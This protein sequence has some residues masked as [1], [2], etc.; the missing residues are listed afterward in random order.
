[1]VYTRPD[2]IRLPDG[3]VPGRDAPT[4]AF[5]SGMV[6][7]S[8]LP[9]ES[10][11]LVPPDDPADPAPSG[12]SEQPIAVDVVGTAPGSGNPRFPD[13]SSGAPYR[14]GL[15]AQQGKVDKATDWAMLMGSC[16]VPV[17][18]FLLIFVVL[19]VFGI[20]LSMQPGG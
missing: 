20:A 16:L 7:P 6:I 19:A 9:R 15:A 3:N 14:A 12:V 10:E 1:M 13:N 8:L 17:I 18:G 2:G 5:R 4:G 11:A